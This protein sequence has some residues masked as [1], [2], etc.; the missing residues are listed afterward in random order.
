MK[1]LGFITVFFLALVVGLGLLIATADDHE[2]ASVEIHRPATLMSLVASRLRAMP[3]YAHQQI[4][5]F[6]AGFRRTVQ[7]HEG[8]KRAVER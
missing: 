3:P 7:K 4:D 8:L 2:L 6:T 1:R 5:R